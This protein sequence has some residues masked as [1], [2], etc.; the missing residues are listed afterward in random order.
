MS[1]PGA[2]EMGYV[3]PGE[4]GV[5]NTDRSR[6]GEGQTKRPVQLKPMPCFLLCTCTALAENHWFPASVS[7]G[8]LRT[9]TTRRSDTSSAP[10]LLYLL[11]T[12]ILVDTPPAPQL[13]IN[14][15]LNLFSLKKI[16][17]NQRKKRGANSQYIR[18]N[19]E[20]PLTN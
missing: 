2:E 16:S 13:K 7:G 1:T 17:I 9:V 11:L 18:A 6:E 15:V 5:A 10:Q 14:Q 4:A 3:F 12:P 20:K 19:V 8:L